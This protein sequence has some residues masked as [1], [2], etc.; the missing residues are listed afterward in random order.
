MAVYKKK[1]KKL[2][3]SS[4]K[5]KKS[6]DK[7]TKEKRNINKAKSHSYS[8]ESSALKIVKG[9][10]LEQQRKVKIGASAIGFII[11]LLIIF[12]LS[13]PIGINDSL[14]NFFAKMGSGS[15]PIDSYGTTLNDVKTAKGYYYVLTDS[16]MTAYNSSGKEMVSFA[17]GYEKP[18]MKKSATRV[19][20][21]EQGGKNGAIFNLSGEKSKIKLENEIITANISRSGVYAVATKS[22]Q[23]ASA[24]SVYDINN[25]LIYEWYSAEDIVNNVAVSPN[26][27]KIAVSTINAV[28]G[29]FVSKVIVLEFD[30]ATPVYSKDYKG[31]VI[32]SIE[33]SHNSG[34]W[35]VFQNSVNFV[36]WSNFESKEY[37]TEYSLSRFVADSG[38]A[39]AVFNRSGDKTD[40]KIIYFSKTGIK[41]NEFDFSGEI[42]DISVHGSHIYCISDNNV[43]LFSKKG[44]ITRKTESKF[45]ADKIF[46]INT[47]E[48]AVIGDNSIEKIKFK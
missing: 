34:F 14:E 43:F 40:S 15:Y 37:N 23:Y 42:S 11:I 35:C 25:T 41:K 4:P 28:G 24:V 13:L 36:K 39:V 47:Y 26:G 10:K 48:V 8:N 9:R 18:V 12:E 31:N 16:K 17:H 46:V 33:T 22:E 29:E 3:S 45:G 20:V 6:A 44:E 27:K 2:F 5:A 19:L 38:G 32:Y 1:H 7:V 30:S 21:F